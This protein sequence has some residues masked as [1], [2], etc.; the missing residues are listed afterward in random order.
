MKHVDAQITANFGL[1][2]SRAQLRFPN[3]KY[4]ST[5]NQNL[6][7]LRNELHQFLVM[8]AIQNMKKANPQI[9]IYYAV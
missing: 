8:E 3:R 5:L 9:N 2:I 1:A 6:I 7:M 4:T